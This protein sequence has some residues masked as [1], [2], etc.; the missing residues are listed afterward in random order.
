M[1][2]AWVIPTERALLNLFPEVLFVDALKDTSKESRPF[3]LISGK[4]TNGKLFTIIR[5]FLP[6]EQSW[7]FR[8]V[9]SVVLPRMFNKYILGRN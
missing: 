7:I 6:N 3:L 9:F 2:I 4:D 8:W 1:A 5:I